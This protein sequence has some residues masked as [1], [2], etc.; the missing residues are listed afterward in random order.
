MALLHVAYER[1][2]SAI[3]NEATLDLYATLGRRLGRVLYEGR[4]FDPEAAMLKD[5]LTKGVAGVVT[6]KVVLELRRGDDY[7]FLET[8]AENATYA[9]DRLSM[10][11][12]R[13]AFTPA[14]RIGALEIQSL[15]VEDS[16]KILSAQLS[17]EPPVLGLGA[18]DVLE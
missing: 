6:G 4:W 14:D 5:A 8:A 15:S 11:K 9:P 7:S 10:E 16:R 3:H 1:L 13:A 18:R 17:G 2:L 12:T